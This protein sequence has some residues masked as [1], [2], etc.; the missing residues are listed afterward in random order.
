MLW[1]K[2]VDLPR[3]DYRSAMEKD[4]TLLDWLVLLERYG[5]VLLTDA[6]TRVGALTDL[7]ERIGF[8]K[9]THYGLV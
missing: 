5:V 3:V 4:E 1:G 2:D 6:S 7:I 8:V 9:P